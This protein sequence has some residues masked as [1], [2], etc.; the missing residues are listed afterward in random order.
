MTINKDELLRRFLDGELSES[1]EQKA[2]HVIADDPELRQILKFDLH[3][4]QNLSREP[5]SSKFVQHDINSA[6]SPGYNPENL[7]NRVMH[8]LKLHEKSGESIASEQVN[9]PGKSRKRTVLNRLTETIRSLWQPREVLWRPV[10]SVGVAVFLLLILVLSPVMIMSLMEQEPQRAPDMPVRQIVE[11]TTDQVMMRF[12]Y[13]DREA[14]SVA[15]AGDFSDWEPIQLNRQ[16]INGDVAWTGIIPL[17]RG[18]HRY[19]FIKDGE[20]WATDP[21]ANRF[22]DDGFGNKNAVISL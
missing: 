17:P 14:E 12:V 6:D 8:S 10:W 13:V 7:E 21:L 18:E 15:V 4:R 16:N 1:E 22:V 5:Q 19:M 20:D 9:M 2:L 3:L 11:Q